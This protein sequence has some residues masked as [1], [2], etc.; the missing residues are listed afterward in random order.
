VRRS[1]GPRRPSPSTRAPTGARIADRRLPCRRRHRRRLG[2]PRSRHPRAL[3]ALHARRRGCRPCLPRGDGTA[4]GA[5]RLERGAPVLAPG[6][7]LPLRR[8][9]ARSA[10]RGG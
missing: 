6:R 4:H 3:P 5:R 10:W 2:R 1:R 8:A 9:A 7:P